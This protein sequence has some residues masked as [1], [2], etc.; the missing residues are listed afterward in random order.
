[1]PLDA[2]PRVE[3]QRHRNICD[4]CHVRWWSRTTEKTCPQCGADWSSRD[5]W[6][7]KAFTPERLVRAR[8]GRGLERAELAALVGGLP[9]AEFESPTAPRKPTRGEILQLA[10]ALDFPPAWFTIQ[11]PMPELGVMHFCNTSTSC[12]FCFDIAVALCDYP[13]AGGGTC[14]K[15]ICASHGK[16]VGHERDYCEDCQAKAL[17]KNR[18]GR[19]A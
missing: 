1:M 5:E 3:L 17:G 4:K 16:R 12:E 18:K 6:R 15:P 7:A 13:L 9:I 10:S 19:S 8:Q 14:D 11:T 2:G